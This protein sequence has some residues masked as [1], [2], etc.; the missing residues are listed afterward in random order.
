MSMAHALPTA[1]RRSGS[2]WLLL[3]SLALNLFFVGATLALTIRT[4]A[5]QQWSRDIFVRVEQIAT[6]LPAADAQILRTGIAARHDAIDA[7]QARYHDA[8]EEI[9][10]TLRQSP[11]KV[12]AMRGAM[13]DTRAA[14]QTFDQVIQAVFADAAA[15]MSAQGR[16]VLAN[17]RSKGKSKGDVNN[18]K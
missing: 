3:G 4:P 6:A 18:R 14:R 10:E 8:R 12:D 2:R 7:A 1:M 5:P 16:L 13:A 11:F 17:W 9:R 15:S